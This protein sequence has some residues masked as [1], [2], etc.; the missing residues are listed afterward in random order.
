MTSFVGFERLT[1]A[2]G[3]VRLHLVY[4]YIQGQW[5]RTTAEDGREIAC[6]RCATWLTFPAL[7]LSRL[8]AMIQS[9]CHQ[10]A[11]QMY[12]VGGSGSD[13]SRI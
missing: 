9:S 2:S 13:A 12:Y 7:P 6:K 8:A 11:T 3:A 10:R 1:L 4:V 5:Y